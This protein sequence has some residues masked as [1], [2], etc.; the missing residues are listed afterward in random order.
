MI[1]SRIPGGD[2]SAR[3]PRLLDFPRADRI[4]DRS[5]TR[6]GT[7]RDTARRVAT[8]RGA[9]WLGFTSLRLVGLDWIGLDWDRPRL[10]SDQARTATEVYTTYTRRPDRER[11]TK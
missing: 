2:R 9:A 1:P 5:A 7:T 3:E 10:R 4:G 6:R 11:R 8:R